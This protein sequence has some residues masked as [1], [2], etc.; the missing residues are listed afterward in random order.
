MPEKRAKKKQN[1]GVADKRPLPKGLWQLLAYLSRGGHENG[2]QGPYYALLGAAVAIALAVAYLTVLFI[3]H[4][5][6]AFLNM[7]SHVH[8][9]VRFWIESGS[10]PGLSATTIIIA[11]AKRFA[12]KRKAKKAAEAKAAK[13]L[14]KKNK[15]AEKKT[16]KATKTCQHEIEQST[17]ASVELAERAATLMPQVKAKLYLPPT[18]GKEFTATTRND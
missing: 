2:N 7:L 9:E 5:P 1:R 6:P 17:D 12:V 18:P 8:P 14:A 4:K 3:A 15:K 11:L 16:L 10:I 13:K